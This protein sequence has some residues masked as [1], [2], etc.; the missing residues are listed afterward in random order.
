M[1]SSD[2]WVEPT[3]GRSRSGLYRVLL[4][5]RRRKNKRVQVTPPTVQTLQPVRQRSFM[6]FFIPILLKGLTLFTIRR[7]V[8]SFSGPKSQFSK[9]MISIL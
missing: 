8:L 5:E 7:Y 9:E 3:G 4:C 1:S 2:L 6:K